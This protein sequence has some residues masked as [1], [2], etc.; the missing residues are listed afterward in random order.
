MLEDE[1]N[2]NSEEF[3]KAINFRVCLWPTPSWVWAPS[4]ENSQSLI[5]NHF[6][7]RLQ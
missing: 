6:T 7:Q 4:P 5:I 1:M 2:F 3:Y